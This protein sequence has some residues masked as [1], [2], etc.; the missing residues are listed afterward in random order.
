MMSRLNHKSGSQGFTLIE[1]MIT[2]A[3]VA[4][5][6]AIAVPAYKDYTTR[7]K[8]GECINAAAVAKVG[9]SEY[10]Q[11]LGAW[12]PNLTEAGLNVA[13][14]ISQYCTALN[15]YDAG[16]GRFAIDVNEATIDPLLVVDSIAP[17]MTPTVRTDSRIIDWRCS[18]GTT[19]TNSLKYLPSTCRGT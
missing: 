1:L 7:A 6:V 15:N 19:S 14:G 12:P 3:V 9:V 17:F 4:I 18:R 16:S 5:L 2:V 11:T 13:L 10:R 8:I